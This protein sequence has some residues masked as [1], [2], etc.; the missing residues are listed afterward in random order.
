MA[1]AAAYRAGNNTP[2]RHTLAIVQA[3]PACPFLVCHF[4][5]YLQRLQSHQLANRVHALEVL[6]PDAF[7]SLPCLA[8]GKKTLSHSLAVRQTVQS[9]ARSECVQVTGMCACTLGRMESRT[10]VIVRSA[11]M[12]YFR[13]P[14]ILRRKVVFTSIV[15]CCY[16]LGNLAITVCPGAGDC[17]DNAKTSSVSSTERGGDIKSNKF[18]ER[19]NSHKTLIAQR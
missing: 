15:L 6:H 17:K 19:S 14:I 1:D 5:L 9:S 3:R 18:Y 16:H 10:D 13:D 2:Q 11:H 12:W 7:A 4:H 8:P